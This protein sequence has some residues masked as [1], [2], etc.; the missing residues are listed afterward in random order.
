MEREISIILKVRGAKAAKKAIS[1][2]FN[3]EQLKRVA[4]YNVRAKKAGDT[5][6]KLGRKAKGA[7]KQMNTLTKTLGRGMAALYLYNRAW[8]TF[9]R[10]FESGLQLE[11]ASEQF[12]RHVGNVVKMLPELKSTT[13]GVI[14]DFDL[15][16]TANRAFQQ[17]LKPE[18]MAGAFKMATVAAQ[19][20][21]LQ[22]SDAINTVT[23]AITKQDEGALNTLGIITKV[24]QAYK[25]QAAL[26]AKNGGVLSKAMSIQ[27]RQSL[28]MQELNRRFGKSNSIQEDGL[29]ILERFRASWK[30]FRAAIGDTLGL[31]LRPLTRAL[32]GVL[33]VTTALLNKLNDTSG[34]KTFI[35]LSATLA[36]IWGGMKF[37]AGARTLMTMF[38]FL[39]GAKVKSI[40]R[41]LMKIQIL[42]GKISKTIPLWTT[43]V[44]AKLGV[45][46]KRVGSIGS[47][48]G[49]FGK[50]I[51]S[52][53]PFLGKLSS[54]FSKIIRVSLSFMRTIPGM[55]IA[56]AG[57]TL[58]FNPLISGL[59]RAWQAGKVFFQL[60]GN[61]DE[62]SGLSK[63]LKRDAEE[64]GPYYNAVEN[65]AKWSLRMQ[66]RLQGLAQGM[67]ELWRPIGMSIDWVS[68]KI[69]DLT[70]GLFKVERSGKLARTEL[71]ELTQ[72]WANFAKIAGV[73]VAGFM[74]GGP[75]GALAGLAVGGLTTDTG[76]GL[77]SAAGS[78]IVDYMDSSLP[79]PASAHQNSQSPTSTQRES[80]SL[81]PL[82]LERE[83]GV[84]SKL[85]TLIKETKKANAREDT[86]DEQ[87][88]V[89]ESVQSVRDNIFMRR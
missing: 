30:N 28:I 8:A 38:G 7:G 74:L 56:I 83:S 69:E 84:E 58:L 75:L 82:N 66:A 13:R 64:L 89:K 60:M 57:L 72:W 32:T 49:G 24:N 15:L 53:I 2:V 52:T 61:F 9:G 22:A 54:G 18:H 34:F 17:G 79:S 59:K 3:N 55:G 26:I 50:R 39:G 67:S 42:L 77:I 87:G 70:G 80:P 62:N 33:D 31:A 10:N 25:T 73:T 14:A 12:D 1:D 78:G 63:V 27:L 41:G 45:F 21:G 81:R 68:N 86:R 71:Q 11:R 37:I 19:R 88:K 46:G 44:A 65:L 4:D 36:G 47:R 51:L 29:M 20:L 85:D 6:E 76:K 5:T 48:L 43:A 16:K 35:Q 40:P 23:A